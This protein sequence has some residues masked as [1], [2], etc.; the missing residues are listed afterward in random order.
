MENFDISKIKFNDDNYSSQK[1]KSKINQTL[2]TNFSTNKSNKI[3]ILKT[4]FFNN[5]LINLKNE[6]NI[7]ESS[8]NKDNEKSTNMKSIES[9]LSQKF[10]NVNKKFYLGNYFKKKLDSEKK[11]FNLIKYKSYFNNK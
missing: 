10:I 6:K 5:K 3:K 2:S 1:S 7:Q 9:I 4:E 11:K 8:K